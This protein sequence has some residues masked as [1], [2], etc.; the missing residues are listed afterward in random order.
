[1]RAA[2]QH[3]GAAGRTRAGVDRNALAR[4]VRRGARRKRQPL[5][6]LAEVTA[7]D[8][9]ARRR[10]D[11]ARD[12][13]AVFDQCDVDGELVETGEKFARAVERIDDEEALA[14]AL[15]GRLPVDS[16]DTTGMPGINARQSRENDASEASSAAV[17]GERPAFR[18]DQ[19]RARHRQDGR[20]RL[21]GDQRQT[22]KQ[23]RDLGFCGHDQSPSAGRN[24]AAIYHIARSRSTPESP[25]RAERPKERPTLVSSHSEDVM[26][27]A[28]ALEGLDLAALL[29]S[30][31]C[32]DLISPVGAIMNGLEVM[33][34]GKD[35]ETQDSPWT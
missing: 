29:C 3:A 30:R 19:V 8:Q 35:E 26:S 24:Q 34:E 5:G 32:H 17:T 33:E 23:R 4:R 7:P 27:G 25:K 13:C 20:R 2:D 16:S 22:I 11:H 6:A 31:V 9:A 15:D 21:R 18:A 14:Q 12:R 10:G 28:I 1:M